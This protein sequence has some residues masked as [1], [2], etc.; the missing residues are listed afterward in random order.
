MAGIKA[1]LMRKTTLT[2]MLMDFYLFLSINSTA[3]SVL[4][5]L[6]MLNDGK[7]MFDEAFRA[8]DA[9][10]G[11]ATLLKRGSNIDSF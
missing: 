4:D 8:L 7:N 9:P 10:P 3:S 1:T 6:A 5:V 2:M 11:C